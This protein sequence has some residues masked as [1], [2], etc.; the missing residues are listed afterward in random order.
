VTGMISQDGKTLIAAHTTTAVETH[1][2]SNGDVYPEICHRS[3]VF[4]KLREH[5]DDGDRHRPVGLD[6]TCI[7]DSNTIGL[8]RQPTAL[9]DRA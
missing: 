9:E 6:L 2:F 8:S 5:N 1:A 7:G 3:R 4:I